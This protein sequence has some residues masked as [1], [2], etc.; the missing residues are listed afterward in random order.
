MLWPSNPTFVLDLARLMHADEAIMALIVA[1]FWHWINVHLVPGRFPLQWMVQSFGGNPERPIFRDKL[2]N[3]QTSRL[4]KLL[5][6]G[7]TTF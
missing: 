3:I 4:S 7:K 5:L 2:G 6:T 1:A